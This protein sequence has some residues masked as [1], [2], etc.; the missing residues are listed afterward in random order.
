M[1]FYGSGPVCG[2]LMLMGCVLCGCAEERAVLP[3]EQET[4]TPLDV[5]A[6]FA[7]HQE[8]HA[9][10]GAF[11]DT[12]TRLDTT[13]EASN[14]LQVAFW[15][16]RPD[17]YHFIVQENDSDDR[18]HYLSDGTSRWQVEVVLDNAI[19]DRQDAD[20]DDPF[21]RIQQLMHLDQ[22]ALAKDFQW[23]QVQAIADLTPAAY[24]GVTFPESWAFALVLQPY[25]PDMRSEV[26]SVLLAFS[27]AGDLLGLLIDDAHSNRRL[28]EIERLERHDELDLAF[29]RWLEE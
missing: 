19:V 6:L 18:Q 26:R 21:A 20:A 5:N 10:S 28:V 14:R 9:V 11:R 4:A 1:R 7:R 12:V 15:L 8:M 22:E 2:L 16:Q 25:S 23:A 3:V 17:Q 13:D 27:P 29:F 24:A